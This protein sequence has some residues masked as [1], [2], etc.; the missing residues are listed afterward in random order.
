MDFE[1][2]EELAEVQK[3]ATIS[4][5]RTARRAPLKMTSKDQ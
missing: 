5:R 1:L 3:L 2:P 4:P